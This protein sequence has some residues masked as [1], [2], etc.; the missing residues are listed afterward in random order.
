[1]LGHMAELGD[2]AD[3][4]HA[5]VGRLAARAGVAGLIAVGEEARPCSTARA[6]K[7]A[8]T[9]KP[10]PRRTRRAPSRRLTTCCDLETSY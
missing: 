4:S 10:S 9:A 6:R 2:I 3:D 8:G 5:E 1:M 7:P